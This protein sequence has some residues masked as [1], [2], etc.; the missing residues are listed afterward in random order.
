MAIAGWG[1]T[2]PGTLSA[3]LLP[4][5]SLSPSGPGSAPPLPAGALRALTVPGV[6]WGE[7]PPDGIL[8]FVPST[9][10]TSTRISVR[11]VVN[12]GLKC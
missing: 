5:T 1:P 3:G 12:C 2:G 4:P 8:G 6:R 10:D 9:S 7:Q 11:L